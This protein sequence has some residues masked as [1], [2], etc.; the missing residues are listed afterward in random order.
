MAQVLNEQRKNL[1]SEGA[2]D[3]G[4][5]CVELTGKIG[6][7]DDAHRARGLAV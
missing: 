1:L 4:W 5:S 2:L 6:T 3:L 7:V